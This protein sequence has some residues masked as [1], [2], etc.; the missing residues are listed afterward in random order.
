MT[1]YRSLYPEVEALLRQGATVY[2]FH[3]SVV[4]DLFIEHARGRFSC[5]H[6]ATMLLRELRAAGEVE[7]L[8]RA[9]TVSQRAFYGLQYNTA[10]YRALAVDDVPEHHYWRW[11]EAGLARR[12]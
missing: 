9:P 3:G 2:Q 12:V 4:R 1:L 7:A 5:D 6:H 8:E 10:A 11:T